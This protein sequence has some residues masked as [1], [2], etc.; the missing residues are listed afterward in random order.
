MS[1]HR[2]I[3]SKRSL[4]VVFT[5]G[6]AMDNPSANDPKNIWQSQE[7]EKITMSS[8]Q[9]Q[10]SVRRLHGRNQRTN[11]VL[12]EVFASIGVY[13]GLQAGAAPDRLHMIASALISLGNIYWAY[14]AAMAF[15][16]I[17]PAR[18]APDE[19]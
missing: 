9:I 15:R 18:L 6:R 8:Q 13:Y 7:T 1:E 14:V 4:R 16:S 3:G 2:S 10:E 19:P 5:K 12:V 11:A 17:R